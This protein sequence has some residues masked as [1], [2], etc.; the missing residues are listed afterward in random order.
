MWFKYWVTQLSLLNRCLELCAHLRP[1]TRQLLISL[2]NQ[3]FRAPFVLAVEFLNKHSKW[4]QR[5]DS[6]MILNKLLNYRS[7]IMKQYNYSEVC[8]GIL[9]LTL[10]IIASQCGLLNYVSTT[11]SWKELAFRCSLFKESGLAVFYKINLTSDPCFFFFL[12]HICQH[13]RIF[14]PQGNA[15]IRNF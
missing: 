4:N 12:E 11:P 9:L 10:K 13:Y 8:I 15:M 2:C 1:D 7:D 5:E 14:S 6:G 3:C